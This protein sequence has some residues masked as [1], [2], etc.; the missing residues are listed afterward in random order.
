VSTDRRSS[1]VWFTGLSGAGKTTIATLVER[2]L[3]RH[4][5]PTYLLDGDDL[6]Q[7]L[8]RDLGFSA[9][10]RTENIRRAGEVAKLMANA[11]LLVLACFISPYAQDRQKV[12]ELLPSGDFVEVFVDASLEVLAERDTKG[13]YAS[14]GRNAVSNLSGVNAPYQA[15]QRPDLRVDTALASATECAQAVIDLLWQRGVLPVR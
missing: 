6:R 13:L 5:V 3:N 9:A 8:N 2:E 14:A 10:D 11:G 7:G 4:G 12:R 15:P 1:V